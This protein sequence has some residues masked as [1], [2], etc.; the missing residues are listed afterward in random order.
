MFDWKA[1]Q[2]VII[3]ALQKHFHCKQISLDI[4][5]ILW[6]LSMKVTRIMNVLAK[7]YRIEGI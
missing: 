2:E 6:A 5:C 7:Q 4:T 3:A 1:N